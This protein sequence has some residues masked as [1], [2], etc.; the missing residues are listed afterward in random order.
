ME[1]GG[2]S[3]HFCLKGSDSGSSEGL[4]HHR[5]SGGQNEAML[6]PVISVAL[7]LCIWLSSGPSGDLV[8]H[9]HLE[10]IRRCEPVLLFNLG[11]VIGIQQEDGRANPTGPLAASERDCRP[12]KIP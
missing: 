4:G 7:F 3:P 6:G 8:S 5:Y 11:G 12:K 9:L 10:P 1:S 2:C